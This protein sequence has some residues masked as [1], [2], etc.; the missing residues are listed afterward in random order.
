MITAIAT[1]VL[2]LDDSAGLPRRPRT[3]STWLRVFGVM[4]A[5]LMLSVVTLPRECRADLVISAPDITGAPG[6]S[7]EFLVLLTD[8][9][10]TGSTPYNV[11]GDTFAMVIGDNSVPI[12]FTNIAIPSTGSTPY[13]YSV[14]TADKLGIPLYTETTNPFPGTNFTAA[15]SGYSVTGGYPGYT[16]VSPGDVYALGLLSYSI[17]ANLSPEGHPIPIHFRSTGTSLS[18]SSGGAIRFSTTDGSITI[19]AAAVPEPSSKIL[20]MT[21]VGILALAQ[22]CRR[23]VFRAGQAA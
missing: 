3:R 6:S 18:N 23:W 4:A 19:T 9:D 11:A 21:T 20:V 17:N 1:T 15:D 13:I 7:G 2:H 22:L 8:T 5:A 16:T 14:S 12:F 10:P